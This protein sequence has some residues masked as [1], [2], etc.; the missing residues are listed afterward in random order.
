MDWTAS[1]ED[2]TQLRAAFAEAPAACYRPIAAWWWSGEPLEHD[3]LAWQL[4]RIAE[5]GCGAVA[6][7]GL[8][9]YGPSGGS[10]A[11]SPRGF[12]PAWIALFRQMCLR[13]R[14]L[15]LAAVAWSPF[16]AGYPVDSA[17]LL[18]EHPDYRA[19][20]LDLAGGLRIEPFG[21]DFGNPAAMA[22]LHGPG[23]LSHD[24]EQAVAD[25]FGDV[26]TA[27]FEDETILFPRWAPSFAAE[28]STAKGYELPVAALERDV[29]PRTPAYRWDAFDVATARIEQAYTA[30]LDR[31][32]RERGLLAG[33]DQ[34]HRRGTPIMSAAF[35]LDPFRTMAWA[36]APGC[37]QMGDA[38]FHLSL[39]DLSG[40]RRVWLEGF[41]SHGWGLTLETQARLLFEWGR[42]GANLFL[43]HGMYYAGRGFFWEWAPPEMGWKQPYA[44]HYPAFAEAI[45]RLHTVLAAGR[46]VPEVAVLYPLSTVWAAT[47]GT[48]A[49]EAAA[50]EA[51]ETYLEL[52]GMHGDPSGAHPEQAERPSLLA[53]AGYDRA[54]I[55]EA[56]VPGW[57]TPILVPACRCLRT[58]TVAALV[59]HAERGGLV[60]LVG[61]LPAWSAE[62]GRQDPE[63]DALVARLTRLAPA[64]DTPAEALDLLPPPRA[65][66][67]KAQ[68][69]RVGDL[70]LAFVTGTGRVRLRGCGSREPEI[71]DIRTGEVSRAPARRADDDLVVELAGPATVLALPERSMAPPPAL[72]E[73]AAGGFERIELP[74]VWECDYLPWGENRWG[75]YRLPAN[76]GSPPVERRTFAH[77]EGDDPSWRTAPVVPEDVEHPMVDLGFEQRMSQVRARPAPA[78]RTLPSGWREVVATYGPKAVDGAGRLLEYSERLGLEDLLL[79]TPF[80]LKGWVEPVKVDFADA[81]GEV[82]SYALVE[83]EVRTHLVIEGGGVLTVCLDGRELISGVESGVLALPVTLTAGWHEVRIRAEPRTV[84]LPDYLG[85]RHPPRTRLAWSF[86]E[87]YTREAQRVWGGPMIHP[88]YKGAASTRLFRRRLRLPEPARLDVASTAGGPIT[89]LFPDELPA[90]EHTLEFL[91][92]ASLA[93]CG[94]T[95]RIRAQ[96]PAGTLSLV[97]DE[98]WE[99]TAAGEEWTGVTPMGITGALSGGGLDPT[100]GTA[101]AHAPRRSPFLDVSWLE[102]PAAVAGHVETVWAEAPAAP[103]PA[104]FAFR[105]PPG[106]RS[107]TLPIDGDV[108]AWLDGEPGVI[109]D[110]RL[111]L[112]E[113]ARVALRVQ[114]PPGH[115]GAGCF[116]E[117]PALEL[118]PGRLQVGRSWHRQGLDSFSGVILHRVSVDVPGGGDGWL[119]IGP[120]AGSV[121]VVVNGR[122]AG[123]LT[124]APWR[125]PVRLADGANL[126]ELEVANTLGPMVARGVPTPFGPE[127]QRVSG[128]LGTPVLWVRR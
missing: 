50:H 29:G 95:C 87:P 10:V 118:G 71:W 58:A 40:A 11:D 16:A 91:V 8:G 17:T 124:F 39:A 83:R 44:R 41:H 4:E 112:R 1:I 89:R 74:E 114:A 24:L 72:A 92:G 119:E 33:Y 66:G 20:R 5:L 109:A 65:E 57:T 85:Y 6:I 28:F 15:G 121:R 54:V 30:E 43:A 75:D 47:C 99:S 122:E 77:I 81:G 46:H 80:G 94:F 125:L 76:E 79:S 120:V 32:V 52:F 113:G 14:E 102:G 2:P 117:H 56:H 7:T 127:D 35:A 88:D 103:P 13:C 42:E 26:L 90:G 96:L 100:Q 34:M 93:P 98:R 45:G 61:P 82:S 31:W 110:G 64:V 106:A 22:A 36:N 123:V 59:E 68:W 67:L 38:R 126:I 37:D 84:H 48:L 62:R 55:D 3:R 49:W 23:T 108:Q 111:A 21:Y 60:V 53:E 101:G 73:P 69:R 25:L 86:T 51:E 78:E 12:S 18:S 116:R 19:E 128:L 107:L 97:T 9:L 70:E 63:F 105:A 27:V 104:W 115:R